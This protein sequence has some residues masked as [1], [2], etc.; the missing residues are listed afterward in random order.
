[1][2]EC[3]IVWGRGINVPEKRIMAKKRL[4][5]VIIAQQK[6]KQLY[7]GREGRRRRRSNVSNIGKRF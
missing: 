3:R 5:K 6:S 4:R 1:M 7:R 2:G